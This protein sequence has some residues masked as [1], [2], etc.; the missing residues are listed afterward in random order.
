MPVSDPRRDASGTDHRQRARPG[1]L[2]RRIGPRVSR[3][4]LTTSLTA[5][6]TS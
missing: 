2:L 1:D 3:R 6:E 5:L 4:S